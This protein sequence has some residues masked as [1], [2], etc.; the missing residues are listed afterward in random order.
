MIIAMHFDII[1]SKNQDLGMISI[2]FADLVF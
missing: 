1:K 2:M